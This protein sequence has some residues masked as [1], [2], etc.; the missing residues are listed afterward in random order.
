MDT[1]SSHT[2][3]DHIAEIEARWEWVRPNFIALSENQGRYFVD[4]DRRVWLPE[5]LEGDDFI[6]LS[7]HNRSTAPFDTERLGA[8]KRMINGDMRA[9]HVA[10]KISLTLS[11][12]DL[13]S[14][15]YSELGGYYSYAAYESAKAAYRAWDQGGQLGPAPTVPDPVCRFTADG[16]MGGVEMLKW[17][18]SHKGSMW[19]FFSFDGVGV[20]IGTDATFR[21]YSRV[22][23]MMITS[24]EYEVKGRSSGFALGNDTVYLDLWNVSMTLE[25]V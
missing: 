8:R 19:A 4:D 15:G 13:P 9:Y 10:D 18:N 20:D 7:D 14:R 6:L 1:N 5:G 12:D 16:A 24:F 2:D 22:Y 3:A 25:E 11:W 23:E 17:H 21:G